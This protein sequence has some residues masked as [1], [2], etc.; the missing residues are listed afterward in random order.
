[1][2]ADGRAAEACSVRAA[3]W[4]EES[5]RLQALRHEVFVLEQGVPVDIEQDG[6]DGEAAH[7]IAELDGEAVG[8]G[9]L[10]VDGRIG[11]L[12][13]RRGF[14][15]LGIGRLLLDEL[16]RL[17]RRRGE[18]QLYLHAQEDAA[19][20]YRRAGFDAEGERFEE[21]GIAHIAMHRH[22]DYR[23]WND[24]VLGLRYPSPADELVIAQARLA[25]R[26]LA[27]LSPQLDHQLF[28]RRELIS[29]CKLFARNERRA[30]VRVLVMDTLPLVRRG[31]GLLNLARRLPSKLELRCLPEH[32]D[33]DGDTLVLRDRDSVLAIPAAT[34]DPGFYRPADRARC[35]T[36]LGRFEDL[37]NAGSVDPE[38]RALSL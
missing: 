35:Q 5:S 6:R 33:W 27:I 8:C 37:W 16:I 23:E 17:A 38:F 32:P 24:T 25:R 10:L 7:V 15:R 26:E 30:R 21:A 19:D 11:R 36:A 20:F 2:G 14:R 34:R 13:V 28:D 4:H 29:A 9:R 12:A 18:R 1:M 31:H 22:L 3:R